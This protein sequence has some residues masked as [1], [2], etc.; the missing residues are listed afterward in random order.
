D[1]AR[2]V[3]ERPDDE[4]SVDVARAYLV[5]IP[6]DRIDN[7]DS[8]VSIGMALHHQFQGDDVGLRL[9]V[10]CSQRGKNFDKQAC[11]SR[12]KNS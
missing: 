5:K 11:V 7:Y 1:L 3:Q 10:E 8:W 12:W 9:W 6:Q 2:M 4:V